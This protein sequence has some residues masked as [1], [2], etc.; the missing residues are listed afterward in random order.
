MTAVLNVIKEEEVSV[1]PLLGTQL[2]RIKF[3]VCIKQNF[4]HHDAR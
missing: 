3:G 2:Y 1:N 4:G